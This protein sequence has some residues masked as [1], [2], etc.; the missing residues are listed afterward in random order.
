[1]LLVSS[2]YVSS[3]EA[4]CASGAKMR[5]HR[6]G[7]RSIATLNLQTETTLS[8]CTIILAAVAALLLPQRGIAAE[9]ITCADDMP[10]VNK[11]DLLTE[12]GVPT[13]VTQYFS[14]AWSQAYD[15]KL[16]SANRV[17]RCEFSWPSSMVVKNPTL[18][19]LDDEGAWERADCLISV[20]NEEGSLSEDHAFLLLSVVDLEKEGDRIRDAYSYW[21]K[22]KWW[23]QI[24]L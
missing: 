20:L 11:N 15:C 1:M 8:L 13:S 5:C 9:Q 14:H 10:V 6:V 12:L 17:M 3:V 21:E 7:A 19:I 18:A 22:N 4:I 23:I 16:D 24:F 2:L